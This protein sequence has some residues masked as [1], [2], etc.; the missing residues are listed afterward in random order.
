MRRGIVV[1]AALFACFT[2]A[3]ARAADGSRRRTPAAPP[4]TAA[5]F[6]RLKPGDTPAETYDLNALALVH[7]K[8]GWALFSPSEWWRPVRGKYRD[9]MTFVDFFDAVGRPDLAASQSLRNTWS[10]VLFYGGLI[11]L[12]GGIVVAAHGATSQARTETY[13]GLGLAGGGL[14]CSIAGGAISGPI[15]SEEEASRLADAYN[16]SLGAH[17]GVAGKT[18]SAA[19]LGWRDARTPW[20]LTFRAAF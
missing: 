1:G 8:A 17:L 9:A 3:P 12:A 4:A 2:V 11:A 15:A 7:M 18:S 13:A 6:E 19:S 20:Q 5:G 16:Q 10:D 14:A